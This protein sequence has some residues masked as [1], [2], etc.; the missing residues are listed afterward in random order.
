V[1]KPPHRDLVDYRPQAEYVPRDPLPGLPFPDI[2]DHLPDLTGRVYIV[3]SGPNGEAHLPRIPAGACT[4]AL[5]RM[6]LQPRP[7]T[8]WFGFDHRLLDSP[9][10]GDVKVPEET[11]SLFGARLANRI[12]MEPDKT[13][14]RPDYY[15]RY[16]PGISGA[17]FVDGQQLLMVGILR[18]LTVAGC[19][20]QFA[21]Y[22]AASEVIL[23]GVDM[24][25]Q[26][27]IGGETNPDVAYKAD[28]P[29]AANLTRLCVRLTKLGMPVYTMS[30]TALKVPLWSK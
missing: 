8:F 22:C 29:W 12:H 23:C 21:Y 3:G 28:W 1:T 7:W 5:N 25:G 2:C 15:F 13:T 27:H 9:W 16:N 14:L 6:I 30:M 11:T 26:Q 24:F 18:G 19:A 4:I 20:L 10:W 17:S